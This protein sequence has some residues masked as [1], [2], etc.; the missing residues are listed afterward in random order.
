M[1]PSSPPSLPSDSA[2]APPSHSTP[3]VYNSQREFPCYFRDNRPQVSSKIGT[4]TRSLSRRSSGAQYHPS[5]QRCQCNVVSCAH[6]SACRP[7]NIVH[8][9]LRC[10]GVFVPLRG[11]TPEKTQQWLAGVSKVCSKTCREH[12]KGKTFR[13]TYG[14]ALL[15][16]FCQRTLW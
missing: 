10:N 1:C 3:I 5:T 7:G 4:G 16:C 14:A 13:Q 6:S 12:V 9:K 8:Y 15:K 11:R 2:L